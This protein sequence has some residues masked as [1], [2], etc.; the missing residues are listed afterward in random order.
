MKNKILGL[1]AVAI[2][3]LGAILIHNTN[4]NRSQR[5][6][7][8]LEA[9]PKAR[10]TD[11]GDEV[12]CT[13]LPLLKITTDEPIPDPY[14]RT[15]SGAM[16]ITDNGRPV[17]N[18]KLVT[19]TVELFDNPKENNHLTDVPVLKERAV[20]RVRGNSSR[21]FDK[22]SYLLK[23]KQDNMVDNKDV[24]LAGMTADHSW[25]IHGPF[26]DRTL[27]RNYLCCHLAGEIMEFSPDVRFCEL[28]VNEEY[29]VMRLKPV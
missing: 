3:L 13:H 5:H 26:M 2:M 23:F 14:I 1:L 10:C 18:P 22:K 9:Q 24:P 20:T 6:Y 16:K 4:Q 21:R 11:H 15:K 27:L 29:M 17:F 8:H 7:Q 12:F 19:A 25:A 28:F